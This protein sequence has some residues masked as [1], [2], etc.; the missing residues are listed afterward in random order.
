[1]EYQ[2]EF[3][4]LNVQVVRRKNADELKEEDRNFLII[5]LLDNKNNPCRFFIFDKNVMEKVLSS[6]YVGLQVLYITFDVVYN[7]QNWAVKLVDVNE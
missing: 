2:E 1:M 5:N 6:S 3:K 4:F 7:N